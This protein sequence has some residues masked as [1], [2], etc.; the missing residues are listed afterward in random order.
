MLRALF[1]TNAV[2]ARM[3]LPPFFI[4]STRPGRYGSIWVDLA[5]ELDRTASAELEWALRDCQ[6]CSTLVVLDLREVTFMDRSGARVIAKASIN[7]RRA[8][9]GLI[10]A[11]GPA[12]VDLVFSLTGTAEQVELFDL[13]RELSPPVHRG[14][15]HLAPLADHRR[16]RASWRDSEVGRLPGPASETTPVEVRPASD[17]DIGAHQRRDRRA[18]LSG[19]IHGTLLFLFYG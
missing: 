5:G 10:V 15:G 4:C 3:D 11:R 1:L 13:D 16:P 6:A 19:T 17:A 9:R 12:R 8:G 18:A 14:D 7:A 2:T